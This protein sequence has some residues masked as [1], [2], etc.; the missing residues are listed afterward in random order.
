MN[1]E[2]RSPEASEPPDGQHE[3][4]VAYLDGELDAQQTVDIERRLAD[5]PTLRRR[6]HELQKTW[7]VLDCLPQASTANTFTKSTI[8][9]V[10]REAT[11]EIRRQRGVQRSTWIRRAVFAAL[12][13]VSL[14]VGYQL[15]RAYQ[16]APTRQ[17]AR[18]LR[19]IENVDLYRS[20]DSLEFLKQLEQAGLF[21]S[22]ELDHE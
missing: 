1:N 8:E 3:L 19:V 7:D 15:V 17:L 10:T 4:L 18:D 21:V 22:E 9:L 13:F 14:I 5:D 12:A 16:T 2:R 20:I 11:R 6:L